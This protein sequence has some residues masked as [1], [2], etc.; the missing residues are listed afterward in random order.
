MGSNRKEI[1]I[2]WQQR[3]E[4]IQNYAFWKMKSQTRFLNSVLQEYFCLMEGNL[5]FNS[6]GDGEEAEKVEVD[7]EWQNGI[8]P[9]KGYFLVIYRCA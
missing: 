3:I 2:I 8:I 5:T 7:S 9:C 4:R 1:E 6:K